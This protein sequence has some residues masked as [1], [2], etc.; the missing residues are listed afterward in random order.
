MLRNGN[1]I[2][3]NIFCRYETSWNG[4]KHAMMFWKT[5]PSTKSRKINQLAHRSTISWWALSSH[6]SLFFLFD[7]NDPAASNEH[8]SLNNFVFFLYR[9]FIIQRRY[10]KLPSPSS[11]QFS[12]LKNHL[13]PP[14]V[15]WTPLSERCFWISSKKLTEQTSPTS[16]LI[17]TSLITRL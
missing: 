8:K 3:Y 2:I 6:C 7:N 10:W 16:P 14:P 17:E 9:M 1:L 11:S 5:F 4:C 12:K 13:H 15:F